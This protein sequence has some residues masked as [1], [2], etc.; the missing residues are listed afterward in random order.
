MY[1]I[2]KMVRSLRGAENM[3]KEFDEFSHQVKKTINAQFSKINVSL[4]L[5]NQESH[6]VF[7]IFAWLWPEIKRSQNLL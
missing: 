6:W 3:R 7:Q 4:L 2:Y 5:D 1:T